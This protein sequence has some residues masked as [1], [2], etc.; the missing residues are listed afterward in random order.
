MIAISD[1]KAALSI[2][3][4]FQDDTITLWV[5]EVIDFLRDAGVKE[6]NITVGI[7]AKGVTDLWNYGSGEGKLSQYFKERAT[8]LALKP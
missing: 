6:H 1:V 7:V 3:G 4:D 2:T 8:Q 5:D